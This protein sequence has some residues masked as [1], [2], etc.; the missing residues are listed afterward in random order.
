LKIEKYPLSFE[1]AAELTHN[2]YQMEF[3]LP[4]SLRCTKILLKMDGNQ[5]KLIQIINKFF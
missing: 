3:T 4:E 5:K 1:K 2:M